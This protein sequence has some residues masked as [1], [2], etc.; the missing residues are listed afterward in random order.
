MFDPVI[1]LIR[2]QNYHIE[3]NLEIKKRE[4]HMTKMSNNLNKKKD[5]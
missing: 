2:I 5:N 3:R 1:R 4:K